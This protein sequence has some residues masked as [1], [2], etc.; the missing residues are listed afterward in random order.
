MFNHI[1]LLWSKAALSGCLLP[2]SGRR[3]GSRTKCERP[4]ESAPLRT[5]AKKYFRVVGWVIRGN[6]VN[7]DQDQDGWQIL[8][9]ESQDRQDRVAVGR[10]AAPV[11]G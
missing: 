2:D 9:Q 7:D 11:R 5:E 1:I 10:W 6:Y 8:R 4:G 3:S